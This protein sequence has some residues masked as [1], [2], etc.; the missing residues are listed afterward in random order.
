MDIRKQIYSLL[1]QEGEEQES[2]IDSIV[3]DYTKL[4]NDYTNLNNDYTKLN[5]TYTTL[6]DEHA[7]YK[8]RLS[9]LTHS[10]SSQEEPKEEPTKD[11]AYYFNNIFS[12]KVA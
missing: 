11:K 1:E 9:K 2:T 7:L 8:R 10:I 12:K 6:N 4:S 3:N 5:E